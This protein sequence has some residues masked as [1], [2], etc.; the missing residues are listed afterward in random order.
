MNFAYVREAGR[1]ARVTGGPGF[2]ADPALHSM[3]IPRCDQHGRGNAAIVAGRN[4]EYGSKRV[5]LFQTSDN[6]RRD[7]A[8]LGVHSTWVKWATP[9]AEALRQACLAQES[10]ISQITPSLPSVYINSIEVTNSLFMGPINLE[11]NR[12]YNAIIGGRGT[13]KSTIL[14]YLRWGVC[15]QPPAMDDAEGTGDFQTKRKVLVEKTLTALKAIVQVSFAV[16]GVT[17]TVRRNS[18]T[19]EL[20]LKIGTGEYTPCSEADIRALLPVQAYSQ[21][22][23][24]NVGVRIEELDRLIRT[25]IRQQLGD[26][27]NQIKQ[28][29]GDLRNLHISIQKNRTAQKQIEKEELEAQSLEQQ[30]QGLRNGLTGF[31]PED[32][33]LMGLQPQYEREDELLQGWLRDIERLQNSLAEP[34]RVAADGPQTPTQADA[35]L[36]NTTVLNEMGAAILDLYNEVAKMLG[37]TVERMRRSERDDDPFQSRF[38]A[39]T[40]LHQD[41]KNRYEAAKARSTSHEAQIKQLGQLE[42]RIKE[43][44]KT[45]AARKA[46]LSDASGSSS[47]FAERRHEWLRLHR[48]RARFLA[49]QCVDLTAL[50]NGQIKATLREGVGTKDAEDKFRTIFSGLSLR[51]TKID[52][53][54]RGVADAADPVD[55]WEAILKELESLAECDPSDPTTG[56]V[57][58]APKLSDAGFSDAEI[59]KICTRLKPDTW[60]DLCLVSLTDHPKFEYRTREDQYI[61]FAEASAGQQATAL[62]FTLLNQDGPPLVIDQPEDDLDNQV[63]L[64]VVEQIW[65]AKTRRQL[66]FSSHNANL[67]VNGDAELVICCDYRVAADQSGGKVKHEGAIDINTIR[68]EITTVMEGGHEAFKLRKAKYG[69]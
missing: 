8:D 32:Q 63:I 26:V 3:P 27:D 55:E 38:L 68:N 12:Q 47:R 51:G 65:Q 35:D 14:E 21:K 10:R 58:A 53:L 29:A 23:L 20:T 69:F 34:F 64:K 48:E 1:L 30:A 60:I 16:N 11:F 49:G 17:H 57:P 40:K 22:Q 25:P 4:A 61:A 13:G 52:A 6:R 50:S 37:Q 45:L 62:L 67:V 19:G 2:E 59:T 24:S 56:K 43:V 9:T 66:I 33:S 46:A 7:F 42:S 41:L 39:I 36:P 28:I 15:D 18:Q 44:R 5:A 31:S 54:F